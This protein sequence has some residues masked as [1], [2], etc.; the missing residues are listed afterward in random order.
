M[1]A[2]CLTGGIGDAIFSVPVINKIKE[3]FQDDVVVLY[4]DHRSTP[5]IKTSCAVDLR[6]IERD[7]L[8]PDEVYSKISDCNLAIWNTFKIDNDGHCN[9]FYA[10]DKSKIG[11]VRERRELYLNNL[12]AVCGRKITDIRNHVKLGLMN[13]LSNEKDYY[14][15][16][17]RFGIDVSFEDVKLDIPQE[18]I[19]RN[20]KSIDS[21]GNY[22]IVHDS[23]LSSHGKNMGFFKSWYTDRWEELCEKL[24]ED[25]PYSIIVHMVSEDQ[26]PFDRCMDHKKFIG[27]DAEFF[28]YLYLISRSDLY[29]GTCSWPSIAAIFLK[30]T[31]FVILRGPTIKRWD[32]GNK[33]STIIRKGD[34]QACQ[35]INYECPFGNSKRNCM[36][37]ITVEEVLQEIRK[38]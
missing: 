27:K 25:N 23:R 28:D 22:R 18:V 9:F 19:D 26:K 32:F 6:L 29:V 33:F 2:F 8:S 16:F 17:K 1:I 12:S 31:K 15:D 13:F 37:N 10:I 14:A 24:Q 34:C 5:I 20:K 36:K 7:F 21:L 3:V 4:F 38:I 11:I 35:G 30:R